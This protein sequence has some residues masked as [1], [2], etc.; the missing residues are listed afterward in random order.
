MPKK[1][2]KH[3]YIAAPWKFKQSAHAAKEVAE[4]AGLVVT[5]RWI[6]FHGDT[7]DHLELQVEAIHDVEDVAKADSMLLL[8]LCVSEGKAVEQGMAIKQGKHIYAVGQPS[9][10]FHHLTNYTWFDSVQEAIDAITHGR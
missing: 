6:D 9:N 4:A 1:V 7:T 5:S 2:S 3:I 8:N 10:V